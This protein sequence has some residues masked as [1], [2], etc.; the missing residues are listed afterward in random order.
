VWSG[1]SCRGGRI[2][3]ASPIEKFLFAGE[4]AGHVLTRLSLSPRRVV[5]ELAPEGAPAA[6]REVAFEEARV[7]GVGSLEDGP[8]EDFSL[9]CP[10][11]RVGCEE[12]GRG[13]WEFALYCEAVGLVFEA[14]WPG[15]A[16]G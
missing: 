8:P 6:R 15:L 7:V 3:M 11:T 12:R 13:R 4:A 5:L 16:G 2:T 1:D 14:R 9:R 10:V